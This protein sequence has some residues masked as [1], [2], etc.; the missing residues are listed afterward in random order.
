M[1]FQYGEWYRDG[2]G[3]YFPFYATRQEVSA[4]ILDVMSNNPG[5]YY[6]CGTYYKP[7]ENSRN[8]D[9]I[10]FCYSHT[11]ILECLEQH[12]SSLN[13]Y[14]G[15]ENITPSRDLIALNKSSVMSINGLVSLQYPSQE[16]KRTGQICPADIG[17]VSRIFNMATNQ[18]V[19]HCEYYNLYKKLKTYVKKQL[20]Y[21]TVYSGF[22][23]EDRSCKMSDGIFKQWES[24]VSF[25]HDPLCDVSMSKHRSQAEG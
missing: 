10:S 4:Y 22:T 15:L 7:I 12:A 2:R 19:E 21:R 24:G 20:P 5:E 8:Y 25:E 23:Q 11:Q 14:I 13:F 9:E 17:I 16:N 6:I 18:V 3:H 1:I